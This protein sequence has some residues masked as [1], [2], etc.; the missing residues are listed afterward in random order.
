MR[1]SGVCTGKGHNSGL[2]QWLWCGGW[3]CSW[4]AAGLGA[5][6]TSEL[7]GDGVHGSPKQ[8]WWSCN[9]L[10]QML[11]WP[12]T[13]VQST[14]Y[15]CHQTWGC[16]SCLRRTLMLW[17]LALGRLPT[18]LLQQLGRGEGPIS[19]M[20]H[21]R[22]WCVLRLSGWCSC[23]VGLCMCLWDCRPKTK[24]RPRWRLSDHL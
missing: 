7:L 13:I 23:C 10:V 18:I 3:T 17:T 15:Y 1:W 12:C 11:W 20:G 5:R 19:G 16:A 14:T 9:C 8:I 2:Q 24:C 6:R 4:S 21:W 22:A